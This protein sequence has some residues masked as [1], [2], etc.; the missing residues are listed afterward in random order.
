VREKS[1]SRLLVGI[2][3]AGVLAFVGVFLGV[4]YPRPE[5]PR[6]VVILPSV[7]PTDEI[8]ALGYESHFTGM[9]VEMFMGAEEQDVITATA[10]CVL[11]PTGTYQPLAAASNVTCSLETAGAI[12]RY[13]GVRD[14]TYTTGSLLWLVNES[15]AT[16]IITDGD[17]ASLTSAS[18][19]L[20]V[21]DTLLL[22]F[23]GV[24]WIELS[25]SDN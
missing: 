14:V 19:S 23:D 13:T 15:Y 12:G 5:V 24:A 22:F 11:T 20:G 16:I 7:T 17:T 4:T 2:I 9:F 21:S 3:L 18:V 1:D 6:E 8:V 10:S 25:E